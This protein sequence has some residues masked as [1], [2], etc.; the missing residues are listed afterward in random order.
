MQYSFAVLN[1]DVY[2]S[3]FIWNERPMNIKKGELSVDDVHKNNPNYDLKLYSLYRWYNLI[4][5]GLQCRVGR[6]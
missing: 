4:T 1:T 3:A 5:F 2:E 6:I